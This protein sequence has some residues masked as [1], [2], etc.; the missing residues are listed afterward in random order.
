V[1]EVLLVILSL[2]VV[3][4]GF[5]PCS[6]LDSCSEEVQSKQQSQP[7]D[8]DCGNCAALC[9]CS[10]ISVL[11][12]N[13]FTYVII[14]PETFIQAFHSNIPAYLPSACF[15]PLIQPPRERSSTAV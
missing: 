2:W 5:L 10:G 9:P 1:K 7:T 4:T 14:A 15:P 8:K 11:A 12:E 3:L 6:I 13:R